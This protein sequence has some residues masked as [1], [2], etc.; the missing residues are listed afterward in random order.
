MSFYLISRFSYF[1]FKI[2]NRLYQIYFHP[3]NSYVG[4]D[5]ID[6]K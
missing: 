6:E 5:N 1:A 4:V 2:Q 3:K